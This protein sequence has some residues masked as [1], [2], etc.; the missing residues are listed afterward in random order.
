MSAGGD[1][2]NLLRAERRHSQRRADWEAVEQSAVVGKNLWD[3]STDPAVIVERREDEARRAA[4]PPAIPSAVMLGLTPGE[5][6][7]LQL[8]CDGEKKTR[9]YASALGVS[10]L[11]FA[12]QQQIVKR[13]KDK[14]KKR[15][16]RAGGSD[17]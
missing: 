11:P 1:L 7:A 14:L 15:L 3:E 8:M 6:K 10:H 9:A 17:E 2:K 12:E 16:K 4:N 13:V 5:V